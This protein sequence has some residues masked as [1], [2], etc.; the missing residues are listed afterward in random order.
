MKVRAFEDAVWAKDGVRVVVRAPE[1]ATVG[2]YTNAN[3]AAGTLGVTGYLRNRITP[4]IDPYTSTVILGDG[5]VSHGG[6]KLKRVRA[7]YER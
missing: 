2:D 5:T 1:N 7:T 6:L 4:I 3:A